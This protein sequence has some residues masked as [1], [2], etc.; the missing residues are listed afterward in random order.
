MPQ[1]AD[2]IGF[3]P[4]AIGLFGIAEMIHN[5]EKPQSRDFV[6]TRITQPDA[7]ACRPGSGDAGHPRG[8]ALGTILGVL[9]GGGAALPAFAAYA[10]EKKVAARSVSLR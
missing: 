7:D 4:I 10:L 3:V 9:P 8:T 5:L 1:L 6:D 2:G